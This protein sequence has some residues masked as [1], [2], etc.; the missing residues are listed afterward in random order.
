MIDWADYRRVHADRRNLVIHLFAV[1]LFAASFV[2]AL[3]FVYDGN[4][5]WAAFAVFTALI[6]MAMQGSGHKFEYEAPLPFTGPGNFLKRW[7]TEQ[8]LTFP[9]FLVSGRWWQQYRYTRPTRED[10]T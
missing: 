8:F 3:V 4:Y 2:M 6:A 7:F 10:A 5:L 9:L 1:P